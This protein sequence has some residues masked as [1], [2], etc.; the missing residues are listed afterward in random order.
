[1]KIFFTTITQNPAYE[2]PIKRFEQLAQRDRFGE[3]SVA[4][5]ADEADIVLFVDVH[6]Q[7]RDWG[8]KALRAHPLMRRFRG[9]CLIYDE[10]DRP[11]GSF[12]G[13]YVCLPKSVFSA[14][15]HQA[16]AYYWTQHE[17]KNALPVDEADLL[18]SFLGAPSH[19][20]RLRLAAVTHPRA[21][22]EIT[23]AQ[24]FDDENSDEAREHAEF[25]QQNFDNIMRRSKFILCPRG[26][27]TSSFRLF[28]TMAYGRV[29]VVIGNDWVA[30]KG[31]DWKACSLRVR[32]GD[33]A[34]LPQL[35]EAHEPRFEEMAQA[36]R[37]TYEAWFA[38]D[39]MFHRFVE[40]GQNL[41]ESGATREDTPRPSFAQTLRTPFEQSDM[42]FKIS[43][44]SQ[45]LIGKLQGALQKKAPRATPKS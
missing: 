19:P 3:H 24:R 20:I 37:E 29:P 40:M 45:K 34:R 13:L 16:C 27:G 38:P 6:Q 9:K 2:T 35:L 43:D 41:L 32:E 15:R 30:P 33:I 17:K 5:S 23:S 12:P 10:R 44:K 26:H 14:Q 25:R 36:A 11:F 18:Y 42:A 1:M 7:R 39:V 22:L 28:E 21:V 31:P 4:Q 8:L